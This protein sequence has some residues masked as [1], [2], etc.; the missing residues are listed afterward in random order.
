MDQWYTMI[1]ISIP[2]TWTKNNS[3]LNKTIVLRLELRVRTFNINKNKV[4]MLFI[5]SDIKILA[6]LTNV[7]GEKTV[8]SYQFRTAKRG[9]FKEEMEREILNTMN[10]SGIIKKIIKVRVH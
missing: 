5:T 10:N 7:E 6:T 3:H 9:M 4:I 8:I 2:F 1:F